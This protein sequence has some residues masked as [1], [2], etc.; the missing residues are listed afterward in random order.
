MQVKVPYLY[1]TRIFPGLPTHLHLNPWPLTLLSP[2]SLF[3]VSTA[4]SQH[5]SSS[6]ELFIPFFGVLTSDTSTSLRM[7]PSLFSLALMLWARYTSP[8]NLSPAEASAAAARA[9][10]LLPAST[11]AHCERGFLIHSNEAFGLGIY[12][13]IGAKRK[14]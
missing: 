4:A 7:H 1:H 11:H 12:N 2:A 14:W 5:F 9:G 6:D 10:S 8:T 13:K 3:P